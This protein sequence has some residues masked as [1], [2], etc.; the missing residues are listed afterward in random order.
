MTIADFTGEVLGPD[1]HGYDATRA[2]WN[3]MHDRRPALIA[4]CASAADVA[5][6]LRHGRERGLRIAI[7]GGGHSLPGHSTVADGLVID[8]RPMGAVAVDPAT[9]RVRVQAG[10]T[11]GEVDAAVQRHGLV[12][13]PGSSPTPASPA[14]RWA[15]A[16]GG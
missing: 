4:R 16:S 15:A 14:S 13:R 6:A 8:L 2:V 12:V 7:R 11:L 3:V 5:P 10:A 9:R 1:H